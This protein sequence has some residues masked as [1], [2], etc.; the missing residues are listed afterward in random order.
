MPMLP[1][2]QSSLRTPASSISTDRWRVSQALTSGG[3]DQDFSLLCGIPHLFAGCACRPHACT[4]R[5]ASP[6]TALVLHFC[7]FPFP[8][9][10][11]NELLEA[12]VG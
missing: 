9:Y 11:V 4:S 8:G 6:S 7:L 10:S 5:S 3:A 2:I 12:K 1:A